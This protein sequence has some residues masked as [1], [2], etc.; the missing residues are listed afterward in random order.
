VEHTEWKTAH[1]NTLR[2]QDR[3][4]RKEIKKEKEVK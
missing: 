2:V 4:G 3:E 1:L